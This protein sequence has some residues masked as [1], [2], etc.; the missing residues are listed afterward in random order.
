M[1]QNN[2]KF[3]IVFATPAHE[4]SVRS[5]TIAQPHA[6][7]GGATVA[8]QMKSGKKE[9][10]EEQQSK[11]NKQQTPGSLLS[12]GYDEVLQNHDFAK[13]LNSLGEVRTPTEFGTPVC[14]VFAPPMRLNSRTRNGLAPPPPGT[15]HCLVGFSEGKLVIYKKRD[16]SVQHVLAGHDG[17]ISCIAVHPTGKLALSGGESDGKLKLWDLTKGR[18]AFVSKIRPSVVAE[19]GKTQYEAVSNIVWTTD[20]CE[21]QAYAFCYGNHITVRDVASGEDILDVD[22]PSRV[23]QLC[24]LSVEQ[25]LFVA[26]ACN[27]GSLP[28]LAV[29]HNNKTEERRAIMAIEPVEGVV[30]GEERFKCIQSLGFG[31]VVTANSAG[32]ISL[33]DLRGA[34]RMI[35]TDD[36]SPR[37]REEDDDSDTPDEN[38]QS[39]EEEELAVDI[40]DG[41]QL[42]TGARVTCM[43]AWCCS[44][45]HFHI[46][47]TEPV[48]EN[49]GEESIE[50]PAPNNE[51]EQQDLSSMQQQRQQHQEKSK[52]RPRMEEKLV[53]DNDALKRARALVAT[54][55]QIQN[56]K[57]LRKSQKKK[58]KN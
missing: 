51:T 49:E 1:D 4:G 44:D 33:M 16:Y 39:D 54:A 10:C 48:L 21:Q 40:V 2:R 57:T 55:R 56:R 43:A 23:N 31:Y 17:G 8:G 24:M 26:A 13:R 36:E 32:V 22:L 15:T 58:G 7:H 34:I 19:E 5:I 20:E 42:G 3:K 45:A 11:D 29:E 47:E 38:D 28:V 9:S 41:V 52:K 50:I 6:D 53:M 25:G 37:L 46:S 30:A 27:D 12:C 14:A 35:T 18:L